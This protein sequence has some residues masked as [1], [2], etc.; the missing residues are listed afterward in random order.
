MP[1]R[2]KAE[3]T[4]TYEETVNEILKK[5]LKKQSN[6]ESKM[7]TVRREVA[8]LAFKVDDA[9]RKARVRKAFI[10]YDAVERVMENDPEE[11]KRICEWID[12]N[13]T[14]IGDRVVFDLPLTAEQRAEY[15]RQEDERKA[16]RRAF[17]KVEAER[18]RARRESTEQTATA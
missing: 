18:Y 17:E 10:L 12:L 4:L 1:A 7:L 3:E 9:A 6:L 2:K 5:I 8:A 14:D 15:E 13:I 11:R 16:R